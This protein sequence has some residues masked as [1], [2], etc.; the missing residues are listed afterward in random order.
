MNTEKD[1]PYACIG[2]V[3]QQTLCNPLQ[4]KPLIVN[5]F[6]MRHNQVTLNAKTLSLWRQSVI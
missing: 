4:R 1:R 5:N 3:E 6:A 2:V